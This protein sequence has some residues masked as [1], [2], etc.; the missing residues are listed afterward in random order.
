[1]SVPQP[2]CSILLLAGGQGARM[3]GRDKGLVT[4]RG[5]PLIAHLHRVVRPLTD[6][7]I[8]SCNRNQSRYAAYA[9]HLVGDGEPGFPGP[10]AG[11]LAGL[12]K[13]RHPWTL[14]LPCDAPQVDHPLLRAMLRGCSDPAQRPLM[15]RQGA[16]WQPMFSLLPG[17]LLPELEIAWQRG[18]RS[19]L[20]AL[21]AAGA[22]A[23]DCVEGDPRLDNFNTPQHLGAQ[24]PAAVS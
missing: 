16:Q 18:E 9:D 20:R 4:W 5:Q 3:G 10:L 1:M 22:R 12:R 8:I 17:S 6:D 21:L 23:L 15:I 13:A 24:L 7:L 2:K 11:V 19:L 14:L